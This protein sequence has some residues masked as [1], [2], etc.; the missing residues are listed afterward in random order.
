M[1]RNLRNAEFNVTYDL[2]LGSLEN[3]NQQIAH[4][5]NIS[6]IRNVMAKS[7]RHTADV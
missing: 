4:L 3:R 6:E 1:R 2:E 7:P 5:E